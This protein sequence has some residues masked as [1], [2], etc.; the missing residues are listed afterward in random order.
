MWSEE[1]AEYVGLCAE[2]PSLRWL[3]GTPEA[4]LKSMRIL[5][6][7]IVDDM[8][9]TGETVPKPIAGRHFS[10]EFVVGTRTNCQKWQL[11]YGHVL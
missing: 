7:E 2:F 9:S 6:S 4:A 3:T 11:P 8:R 5:V 10:G 1:D